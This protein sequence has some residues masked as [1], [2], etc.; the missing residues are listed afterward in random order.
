MMPTRQCCKERLFAQA[1]RTIA[2]A[3]VF[4]SWTGTSLAGNGDDK[5][6]VCMDSIPKATFQF[7]GL[8][9]QRVKA[10]VDNWL[11]VTPAKNPGLL[12]MFADREKN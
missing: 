11:L 7:G 4:L 12:D 9:G 8:L 2:V 1:H 5:G 6:R 3:V 10:N